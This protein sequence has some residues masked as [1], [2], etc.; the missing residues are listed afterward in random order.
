M[1]SCGSGPSIWACSRSRSRKGPE[2]RKRES[3][4]DGLL[5][6][7]VAYRHVATDRADADAP[8]NSP[9]NGPSKSA[10]SGTT[11]LTPDGNPAGRAKVALAIQGAQLNILN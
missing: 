6:E 9:K 4:S 3:Q 1:G 5:R 11:I 7:K 8:A 10:A 2:P